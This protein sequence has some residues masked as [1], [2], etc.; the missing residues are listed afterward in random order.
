MHSQKISATHAQFYIAWASACENVG[1]Y[2]KADE[3]IV[4]GIERRA[5]PEDILKKY[6][7]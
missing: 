2:K 3:V 1:S 7:M 5:K 6:H 4:L